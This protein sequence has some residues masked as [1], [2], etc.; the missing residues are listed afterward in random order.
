VGV[1]VLLAG[2]VEVEGATACPSPAE[3]ARRLGPLLPDLPSGDRSSD[4]PGH[5]ARLANVDGTLEVEL[6]GP[7]DE[8]LGTRRLTGGDSCAGLA[9]AAAVVIAAWE[10][11]LQPVAP[12]AL[13][14][15][16]AL[17]ASRA[18]WEVAGGF[19]ASLALGGAPVVAPGGIVEGSFAARRWRGLAVRA[20]VVGEG[21][22]DLALGPGAVSWTR[23]LAVGVGPRYRLVARAARFDFHVEPLVAWVHVAGAGF[24]TDLGADGV[25]A[26]IGGGVRASL[27]LGPSAFWVGVS[28][29]AWLRRQRVH[30][31]VL[32]LDG[33]LPR[34]E[35][36][37]GAGV[38][39]GDG[40]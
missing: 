15:G 10:A 32:N 16:P 30:V 7:A 4:A 31:D 25:D 20:A 5:R 17:R 12:P 22:R 13:S 35:L 26:G 24:P 34:F 21:A 1:V 29:A 23:A 19:A 36:D 28:A 38:A 40:P 14:L 6:F 33:E 11:E 2:L 27:Q 3:V 37:F 39:L 9:D 8:A 18:R